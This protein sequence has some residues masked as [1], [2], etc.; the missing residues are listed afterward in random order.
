MDILNAFRRSQKAWKK[1]EPFN[2]GLGPL[3]RVAYETSYRVFARGYLDNIDQF[4]GIEFTNLEVNSNA[5]R[6]PLPVWNTIE[7]VG[8]D[9]WDFSFHVAHDLVAIVEDLYVGMMHR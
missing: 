4:R 2:I 1:I 7:N 9:I 6:T 5:G 3:A 8:I